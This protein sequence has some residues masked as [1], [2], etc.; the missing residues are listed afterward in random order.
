MLAALSC[1]SQFHIRNADNLMNFDIAIMLTP[2]GLF[3]NFI[4][5]ANPY[6]M[7][8]YW[9]IHERQG[10]LSSPIFAL[11]LLLV[12]NTSIKLLFILRKR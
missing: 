2:L 4:L 1:L 9:R 3:E 10:V 6:L 7:P 5:N 11:L 12:F 8:F